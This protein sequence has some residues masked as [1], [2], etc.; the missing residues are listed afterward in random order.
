MN[1]KKGM[2][3]SLNVIMIAALITACSGGNNTESTGGNTGNSGNKSNKGNGEKSGEVVTVNAMWMYDWFKEKKWGVDPVT[4]KLTEETGVQ[5]KFSGPGG[6]G[7][8]KANVMLV[9]GDYPEV[10]WMDRGPIWDKYVSSGALYAIDELAKEYGFNDL[11]GKYIPQHVVDS[12]KHPDG[13]LYGIPNWFNDKGE[14]A[15]G[16]SVMVRNDIYEQMGS[17]EIKTIQDLESYLYKVRDSKPTFNGVKVY[18]L[19][20]DY[21]LDFMIETPNLWGSKNKE[22]RYYDEANKQVKFWMYNDSTKEY[23]R[24]LNKMFLEK[25]IDPEN[26]SNNDEKR[27]EAYNKGKWATSFSYVWDYW[28]PNVVL[29]KA[30]PKVFYKAI[31]APAGKEGV[32]PYFQG[33]GT[34]GWNVSVITKNAKN[35]EAIIRFFNHYMSPEGQIAS[36]YGIEGE[37][38]DMKDGVPMLKD[39]VYDEK[40]KDWEAYG[41]K[42]GIRH[43]DMNQNQKYNWEGVSESPDRKADRQIAEA[44]G[45][46]GTALGILSIDPT[47]PEGIAWA[48]IKSGLLPDITKIIMAKSPEEVDTRL[49]ETL[50][51]YEGMGL[52]GVEEAWTK[53][54]DERQA[55]K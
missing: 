48:N 1:L 5:L 2:L 38:Y 3:A 26:F 54:Y 15:L 20:L 34:V 33:Y 45:F 39:G 44:A 49:A 16:K 23:L 14:F 51:K 50:K 41:L 32:T 25:M 40:M 9:S 27:N 21:N 46:D 47:T 42:T 7:E 36:F 11:V 18:P 31:P 13:H 19:G 35:P 30:D 17:P 43:L 53:Q 52:K 55:A 12:L 37:T 28:G 10:M 4:K 22:F 24:W 8:E 29:K 6:N